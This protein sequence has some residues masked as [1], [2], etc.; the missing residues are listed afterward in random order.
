[1]SLVQVEYTGPKYWMVFRF[2]SCQFVVKADGDYSVYL[3]DP[4]LLVQWESIEQIV[5]NIYLSNRIHLK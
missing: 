4:D 5:S 3:A 1:M 2:C